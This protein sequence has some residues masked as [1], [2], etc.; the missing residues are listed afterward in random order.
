MLDGNFMAVA[1]LCVS[2]NILGVGCTDAFLVFWT[3]EIIAG[4]YE[5]ELEEVF[6]AN[7]YPR[8]IIKDVQARP[9][10]TVR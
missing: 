2:L 5:S 3:D 4:P 7:T 6:A 8:D 1:L 10:P 9:V